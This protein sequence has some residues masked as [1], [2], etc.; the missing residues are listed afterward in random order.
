MTNPEELVISS[1]IDEQISCEYPI[2]PLSFCFMIKTI[3][4]MPSLYVLEPAGLWSG[5]GLEQ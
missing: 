3:C 5:V 4:F 2:P 1:V